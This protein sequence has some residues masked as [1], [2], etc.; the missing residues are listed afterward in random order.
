MMPALVNN[1]NM[2]KERCPKVSWIM[3]SLCCFRLMD[4]ILA[5]AK[6]L[7][8]LVSP[9]SRVAEVGFDFKGKESVSLNGTCTGSVTLV[10]DEFNSLVLLHAGGTNINFDG[11]NSLVLL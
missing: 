3:S 11:C 4:T 10:D 8:S 6:S 7:T 9:I 5:S 2:E 1:F